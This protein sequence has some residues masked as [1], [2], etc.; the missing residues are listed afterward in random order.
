MY[1]ADVVDHSSRL[2]RYYLDTMRE[3]DFLWMPYEDSAADAFQILGDE[4]ALMTAPCPLF[5]DGLVEWCY[6][7]RVTRQFGFLQQIPIA[8]PV[9]GHDSFHRVPDDW[10]TPLADL[11]DRWH[12]RGDRIMAPPA[13]SS[14]RRPTCTEEYSSWYDRVTRRFIINPAVW[15]RQQGF[16]GTQGHLPM[17]VSILILT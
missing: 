17:A 6:T 16:Q 9:P 13:Y 14:M 11:F 2:V 3:S 15:P 10:E 5:F 4:R 1:C 7:D 12:T 8:S